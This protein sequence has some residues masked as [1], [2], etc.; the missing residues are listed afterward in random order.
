M[1]LIM[2]QCDNTLHP[3][4]MVTSS[5]TGRCPGLRKPSH[6]AP[7]DGHRWVREVLEC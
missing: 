2:I 5:S 7:C 1:P 6:E 3:N 4:Q